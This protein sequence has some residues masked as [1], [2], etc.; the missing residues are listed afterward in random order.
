MRLGATTETTAPATNGMEMLIDDDLVA[1][2]T[3]AVVDYVDG[4]RLA[5][6]KWGTGYAT[7]GRKAWQDEELRSGSIGH[8]GRSYGCLRPSSPATTWSSSAV[9][10]QPY[11]PGSLGERST[12]W[13]PT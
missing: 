3:A 6:E 10:L 11:R 4:N 12:R 13:R 7:S 9:A 1:V 8:P 5:W 2:L